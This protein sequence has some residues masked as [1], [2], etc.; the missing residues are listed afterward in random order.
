MKKL[1]LALFVFSFST[2]L[3]FAQCVPDMSVAGDPGIHPD[4]ATN[5]APAYV[6]TPYEQVITAVIPAD[7]CVQILPL[8]FPCTTLAF[9]SVI[10]TSVTGLPTGFI[11]TCA[12][13]NCR[14][15][16]NSINCAV[17]TGTATAGQEGT[18]PLT[19]TLDAYVG[20]T[21]VPNTFTI[22][23]YKIII[24]PAVSVGTT[25]DFQFE[26][27]GIKPNPAD[28]NGTLA[29]SSSGNES[30]SFE[31]FNL[32]GQPVFSKKINSK[33]GMNSFNFN[34][35]D[36]PS[37]TYVYRISNGEKTFTKKLIVTH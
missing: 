24:L 21:G 32:I 9:D 33:E 29:F 37:G 3:S 13:P 20:G 30:V 10:V 18:Y 26:L 28:Q 22:D 34:T 23:Y 1:L 2:S 8:P 35:A 4:S 7:T 5:F 11:F 27:N 12:V 15:P 6:G 16:G 19:F 36:L 31:I 14:F 17:I 25:I